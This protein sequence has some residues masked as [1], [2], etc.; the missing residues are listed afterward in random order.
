MKL[1]DCSTVVAIQQGKC[2]VEMSS[3]THL[4][5]QCRG[6]G[7]ARG[8]E[9]RIAAERWLVQKP[10]LLTAKGLLTGAQ[11]ILDCCRWM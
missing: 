1:L 2:H 5:V 7:A 3:E 6:G 9:M 11:A 4:L 10:S 8:L